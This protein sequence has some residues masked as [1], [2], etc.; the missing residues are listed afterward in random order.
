MNH[1]ECWGLYEKQFEGRP[2]RIRL[3]EGIE[4]YVCHPRYMYQVTIS[5]PLNEVD[6]SGFPFAEE[7]KLL[8]ELE[9]VL[10]DRLETHQVAIFVAVIT[11][12]GNRL[13]ILY[14]YMPDFCKKVVTEIN[15]LWIYHP[16]SSNCL[17]DRDWEMV[18]GLL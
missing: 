12:Q 1:Q 6:E 3:N 13:Y 14:T 4:E 17:E 5:V 15:R 16:L 9:L 8:D 18:E 2:I 7:C 10:K 11:T